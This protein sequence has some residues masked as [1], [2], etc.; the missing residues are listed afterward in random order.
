MYLLV[1]AYDPAAYMPDICGL[2]DRQEMI[3]D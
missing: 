1:L 3:P 2:N